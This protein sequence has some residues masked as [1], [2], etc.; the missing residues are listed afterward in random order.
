MARPW[1]LHLAQSVIK[2]EMAN[3]KVYRD[4]VAQSSLKL[5]DERGIL[6]LFTS[7]LK[8]DKEAQSDLLE[9]RKIGSQKLQNYIRHRIMGKA[10]TQKAPVRKAKLRTFSKPNEESC[11]R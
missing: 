9:Y 8:A 1:Y 7:D 5:N 4:K 11:A 10:S 6:H 3:V 2:E